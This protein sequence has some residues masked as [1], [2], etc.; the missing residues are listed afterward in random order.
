MGWN[1]LNLRNN[2]KILQNIN[3][4]DQFYFVHSYFFDVKDNKNVICD[5]YY[6]INIP[7]IIQKDNIY[8]FQFH[9]EKSGNSG[10]KIL[11]NWLKIS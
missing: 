5:T 10:L 2:N 11:N 1:N 7:A 8:G 9:P 3:N 4:I 6:G